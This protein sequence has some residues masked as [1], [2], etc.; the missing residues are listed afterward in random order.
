MQLD[1]EVS[2]P[3]FVRAQFELE[4]TCSVLRVYMQCRLNVVCTGFAVHLNYI[5]RIL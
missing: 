3:A 2:P 4:Y 1:V 5:V